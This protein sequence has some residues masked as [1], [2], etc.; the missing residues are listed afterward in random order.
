MNGNSNAIPQFLLGRYGTN[1]SSDSIH[2]FQPFLGMNRPGLVSHQSQ[3]GNVPTPSSSQ[4]QSAVEAVLQAV[5]GYESDGSNNISP[6]SSIQGHVQAEQS[7]NAQ[8]VPV[9]PPTSSCASDLAQAMERER[10]R[11]RG[12]SELEARCVA[13]FA[14]VL[15]STEEAEEDLRNI[16][17]AQALAAQSSLDANNIS[18]LGHLEQLDPMNSPWGPVAPLG[19][20]RMQLQPMDGTL[21]MR[22][23]MPSSSSY[24]A[25]QPQSYTL[26]F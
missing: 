25:N 14:Q 24:S 17:N 3:D 19:Y 6:Q 1:A 13:S 5:S 20:S 2:G 8:P 16:R 4:S 10:Q 11:E 15:L 7:F 12:R 9:P 21:D 22:S 23:A 26:Q 18:S